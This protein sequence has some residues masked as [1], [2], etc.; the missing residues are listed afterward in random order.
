MDLSRVVLWPCAAGLVAYG[1]WCGVDPHAGVAALTGLG[2]GS[3][4]AT[5]EAMAMYGGLLVGLGVFLGIG[6]L[7]A[8]WTAP[9]LGGL[10]LAFGGLALARLAGMGLHGPVGMQV[11]AATVELVVAALAVVAL[12]RHRPSSEPA[13]RA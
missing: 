9:A 8:T 4:A 3:A 10:A 13:R 12:V 7:R 1:L 6:A 5:V 11:F 2:I